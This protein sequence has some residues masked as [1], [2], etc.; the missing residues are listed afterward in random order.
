VTARNATSWVATAFCEEAGY[1]Y[2][3][4]FAIAKKDESSLIVTRLTDLMQE[5]APETP[6][7][8]AS[9]S[10]KAAGGEAGGESLAAGGGQDQTEANT[11]A[12][13]V[14]PYVRCEHIKQ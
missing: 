9:E 2:P 4:M 1:S 12:G 6:S 14:I 5:A 7:S 10:G 3:D 8:A 13:E 11:G